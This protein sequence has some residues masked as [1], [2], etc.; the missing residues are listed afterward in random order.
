MKMNQNWHK[1]GIQLELN[2][3]ESE[4]GKLRETAIERVLAGIFLATNAVPW[5]CHRSIDLSTPMTCLPSITHRSR[6]PPIEHQTNQ[7]PPFSAVWLL[8]ITSRAESSH[9]YMTK[10]TD[11]QKIAA[12]L[13]RFFS[14]VVFH[15]FSFFS[16]R[17]R[18]HCK[19]YVIFGPII[20]ECG[21]MNARDPYYVWDDRVWKEF[22]PIQHS[23]NK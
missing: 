13:C 12:S 23:L 3:V 9:N 15:F 1:I 11:Y 6:M 8:N 19:L 22:C 7:L 4:I 10:T 14:A 18:P 17:K 5:L 20:W 2:R 16:L 21:W